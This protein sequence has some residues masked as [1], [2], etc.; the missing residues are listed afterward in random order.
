MVEAGEITLY[1]SIVSQPSRAVK[2]VLELGQV[3][4]KDVHFD[5]AK[6]EHK[7]EDYLKINPRGLVPFI[8]EGDFKLGESNAILKYIAETRG[9]V[10]STLWPADLKER[11]YVDQLLEWNQNHFRPGVLAVIRA[12][13]V[14]LRAGEAPDAD[15]IAFL[16]NL[17]KPVLDALEGFLT[18]RE[19][20]FLTG[21]NL[22]IADL[23]IFFEAT[24]EIITGHNF[25]S[26]PHVKA[27]YEKV[28]NVPEVKAIHDKWTPIATAFAEKFKQ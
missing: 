2:A 28:Q 15:S 22:T 13:M 21:A 8:T 12:T 24:D 3:P 1:W 6:G 9:S 5:F 17:R 27:W 18:K 25:D 16:D 11:A 10:P 26:Y 14:A 19:G 7:S 4:H 23:Q 20:G